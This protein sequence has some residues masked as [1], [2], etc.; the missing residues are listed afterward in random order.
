MVADNLPDDQMDSIIQLFH[1]MD[2]D[3]NGGLS[4]EELKDG[5]I[6][7]GQPVSDPDVQM[8]M[9]AVGFSHSAFSSFCTFIFLQ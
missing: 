6:G 3:K 8:L 5:L 4:F 1:M 2:T 9:E 7:L